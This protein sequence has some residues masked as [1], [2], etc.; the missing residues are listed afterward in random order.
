MNTK[1][2]SMLVCLIVLCLGIRAQS[3]VT[4][5]QVGVAIGKLVDNLYK[6]QNANGYWD[7]D[8][9][10][11]TS[12]HVANQWG[13]W[14]AL[15]TYAL[16]TAGESYQNPKLVKAVEF[17]KSCNMVG[18]YS[19]G[20]RAHVWASLPPSFDKYLRKD[21]TFLQQAQHPTKG[22]FNYVKPAGNSYD[23]STTQYGILGVWEGAKHNVPVPKSFWE[24]A[25]K[26]FI[27]CQDDSGGWKYRAS[28]ESSVV[29]GTM[30]AAGLACLFITQDYL[31]SAEY[32]QPGMT[33]KIAIQQRINKALDW[34][35]ANFDQSNVPASSGGY[36][37]YGVERIGLASG[38]KFFNQKDWYATI[39]EKIVKNT[40]GVPNSPSQ[41][42][43]QAFQLLFL[44]RGRVPVLVNKLAI[45][46]YDWNNRPRDMARLTEWVS[47]EVEKKMIWQ[48]I[49]IETK[50]EMWLEAPMLY[51]ASHQ[52]LKLDDAQI[53]KIK[54][55][56]ELGGMLITVDE[57]NGRFTPSVKDLY[58]KIFPDYRLQAIPQDDEL[59]NVCYR[60]DLAR[61]G[62]AKMNIQS[63]SNGIRH[64]GLH[65]TNDVAWIFHSSTHTDPT[66]W[67]LM[68]NAYYYAT[69]KGRIRPRLDRHF[70]DRK[71]N[72]GGAEMAMGRAKYPGNWNPEPLAWEVQGNVM[73]NAS[74][75]IVTV[76]EVPLE[77]LSGS[78]V[79]LV[80]IAG[81][82]PVAF[83]ASQ[84]ESMKQYVAGGGSL[85]FENAGGRG[86]FAQS[87][88]DMLLKAFPEGRIRPLPLSSPILTGK[89]AAGYDLTTVA[90][91]PYTLLKTGQVT[92]PRISAIMIDNQPRILLS[93]DDLTSA[94][95]NQPVWGVLGYTADS[96]Q[97]LMAN[98]IAYA[99]KKGGAK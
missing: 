91:R 92:K 40:P 53:A 30:S 62:G 98:I 21:V 76:K 57:G 75:G 2:I 94:M 35:A 49:P 74:K 7:L 18:V 44:V 17:L 80:H 68:T 81:T 73:F 34:W 10:D 66:P 1:F 15:A 89:D 93:G 45:N 43:D 60:V 65:I 67:M 99:N 56:V 46:G 55:Y 50:P 25:E 11:P 31:H 85:F 58:A 16:L 63:L 28:G 36:Y 79:P 6:A 70:V 14:S 54:R 42:A 61:T 69:E 88:M 97:K 41:V 29:R 71:S 20:C 51:L 32:R 4:D 3:Q 86:P 77:S 12:P 39:A 26:H 96:A 8:R 19:S 47:D 52:P 22:H 78:G 13:G 59:F 90:Y 87:V 82:E 9:P 24:K 64:L 23:N 83:S 48:V 72:G 33:N 84:I 37:Y 95:L 5:K 27:E 38:Y